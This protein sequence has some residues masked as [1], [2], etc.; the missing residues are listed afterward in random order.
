[1]WQH[2]LLLV[3]A[4][5][6]GNREPVHQVV[7]LILELVQGICRD[8]QMRLVQVLRRR[9]SLEAK[10]GQYSKSTVVTCLQDEP[11]SQEEFLVEVE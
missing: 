5:D 10:H 11:R 8:E 9:S 7:D 4:F 2:L 6:H 1:M 3:A